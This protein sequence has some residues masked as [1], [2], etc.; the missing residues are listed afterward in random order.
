MKQILGIDVGGTKIA[1]GLVDNRFRLSRVTIIPTSQMDL[2][3]QLT[4]LIQDYEGF[5]GIGVGISGQV[6][7]NGRVIRLPN[8]P[9]FKPINLKKFLVKKFKTTTSVINDAKAFGLAEARIG[10][11]SKYKSVAGMILGTGIGVGVVINKKVYFGKDGL[12]GEFEHTA[13]LDGK[14]IRDYRHTEGGFKNVQTVKKYL[15]TMLSAVVL[16]FNPD[17][18]ILGGGW[19]KLAGMEKLANA[20]TKNVGGYQNVTPVKIS[21]LKHAG[22]IGAAL[23][24]LKPRA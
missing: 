20:L 9:S 6:L 15:K 22:I 23:P 24:L 12:A 1:A 17:I 3:G 4:R 7:A 21:K 19:S 10:S 14:M 5:S 13:L 16:S 2:V 18:I 8:I 11:G